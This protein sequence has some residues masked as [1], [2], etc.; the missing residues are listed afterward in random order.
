MKAPKRKSGFTLVE[1]AVTI[2][3]VAILIAVAI[4]VFAGIIRSAEKNTALAEARSRWSEALAEEN[5]CGSPVAMKGI[6]GKT[7]GWFFDPLS[8]LFKYHSGNFTVTYDTV[9]FTVIN[10][11]GSAPCPGI[12]VTDSDFGSIVSWK[13]H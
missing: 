7:C 13:E 10:Y 9:V 4:P 12:T 5:V 1:L 11:D 3:V 6:C 8:G 2:V